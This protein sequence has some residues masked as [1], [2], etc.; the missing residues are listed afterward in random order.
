MS[1]LQALMESEELTSYVAEN[2]E[3]L[4]AA[5]DVLLEFPKA[6]KSYIN[7]NLNEF[8][9]PDDLD[10]TYENIVTFVEA[11]TARFI[12]EIVD[13]LRGNF[14]DYEEND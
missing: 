3:I 8:I 12:T 11:G 9:E 1:L 7:E 14:D 5:E 13:M 2:E 6:L 4:E 10:A